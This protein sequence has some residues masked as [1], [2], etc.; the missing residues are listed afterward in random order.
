MSEEVD[1]VNIN[2]EQILAA[3]LNKVGVVKMTPEELVQDFSNFGI[4]VNPI[5][6]GLLEFTLVDAGLIDELSE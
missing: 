1:N 2:V 6:D 4:A 3:I 5:E